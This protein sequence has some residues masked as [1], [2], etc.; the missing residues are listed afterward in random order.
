MINKIIKKDTHV[1]HHFDKIFDGALCRL[2]MALILKVITKTEFYDL[3]CNK[4]QGGG[5]NV[6]LISLSLSLPLV[7]K[8][9][10][11]C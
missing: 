3:C 2:S 6:Y 9:Q 1:N 5:E 8:G 4:P 7:H 11:L 10:P